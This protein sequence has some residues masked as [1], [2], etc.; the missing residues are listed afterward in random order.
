MTFFYD[1]IYPDLK[2]RLTLYSKKILKNNSIM[3]YCYPDIWK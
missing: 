2:V 1:D 3:E